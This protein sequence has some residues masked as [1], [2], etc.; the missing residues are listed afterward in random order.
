MRLLTLQALTWGTVA[1]SVAC[2]LW[3]AAINGDAPRNTLAPLAGLSLPAD[4]GLSTEPPLPTQ[5]DE[6]R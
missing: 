1:G 4:L 3:L 2:A 5:P 6:S